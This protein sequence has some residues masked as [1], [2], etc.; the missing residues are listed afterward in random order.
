MNKYILFS[1]IFFAF[2]SCI[3]KMDHLNDFESSSIE[4]A[5][6]VASLGPNDPCDDILKDIPCG[7]ELSET[8]EQL[9]GG[10][11]GFNQALNNEQGSLEAF[12]NCPYAQ[13]T[14]AGCE[15]TCDPVTEDFGDTEIL[16]YSFCEN[17]WPCDDG[18]VSV[19]EQEAFAEHI[20]GFAHRFAPEC[21]GRKM[22]PVS[23]NISWTNFG[24]VQLSFEIKYIENCLFPI[25]LPNDDD[26]M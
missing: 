18:V 6:D 19:S 12:L 21:N 23:Y 16:F 8:F 17:F 25:P 1:V 26:S 22:I 4:T 15:R 9:F 14:T 2:S 7:S 24:C 11:T 5:Q 20:I 3:H 10:G 13:P